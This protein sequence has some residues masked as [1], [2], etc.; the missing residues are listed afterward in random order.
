MHF[1]TVKGD[2][3]TVIWI[4]LWLIFSFII[5]GATF[6]SLIIQ[7]NQKKTWEAFAKKFG[8]KY[9]RGTFTGPCAVEGVFDGYDVSLFTA[10]QQNQDSRKNR[11]VTGMQVNANEEFVDSV[12]IGSSGVRNFIKSIEGLSNH[13]MSGRKWSK[14]L[15]VFS[16]NK[17]AIDLFLTDER[18]EII[19]KMLGIKNADILLVF[20]NSESI[21]RV[22]TSN[23]LTDL[24]MLEK[25]LKTTIARYKKL[26]LSD[27]EKTK[28]KKLVK[29]SAVSD[30]KPDATLKKASE[31]DLEKENSE[32]DSKE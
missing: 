23:P 19:N 31:E 18:I 32:E 20:E 6:W 27:E 11:K 28:L 10:E 25:M 9:M 4:I 5:L 3:L 12:A 30:V 13:D 2:I 21:Y 17:D 1:I 24:D 26:S 14:D 16:N 22:E 15:T 8:L 29:S 7:Y